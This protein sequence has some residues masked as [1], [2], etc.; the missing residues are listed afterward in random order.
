MQTSGLAPI[1]ALGERQQGQLRGRGVHMKHELV[2]EHC[3]CWGGC[4]LHATLYLDMTACSV[5]T[6]Q[7]I[8]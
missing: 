4:Q 5:L 1:C 3:V 8:A 7:R 2:T 6:N